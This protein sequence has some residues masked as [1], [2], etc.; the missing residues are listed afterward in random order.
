MP[1]VEETCHGSSDKGAIRFNHDKAV[2]PAS[3]IAAAS[4]SSNS[5]TAVGP[6]T[7]NAHVNFNDCFKEAASQHR[8][9]PVETPVARPG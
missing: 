4:S 7:P 9:G 1:V 5:G 2:K 8:N 6:N 3:G